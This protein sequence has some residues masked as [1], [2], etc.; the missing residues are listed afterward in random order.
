MRLKILLTS[1]YFLSIYSYPLDPPPGVPDYNI[2]GYDPAL[3]VPPEE[4]PPT[5]KNHTK[6]E[7]VE[8]IVKGAVEGVIAPIKDLIYVVR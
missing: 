3:N 5:S 2:K 6:K 4:D 8:G 1:I 7:D